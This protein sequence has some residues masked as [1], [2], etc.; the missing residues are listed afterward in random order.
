MD[1]ARVSVGKAFMAWLAV[2]V[3][4]CVMGMK[5]AAMA[6]MGTHTHRV[7]VPLTSHRFRR[8]ATRCLLSESLN[9]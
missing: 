8:P 4:G 1:E 3:D 7:R 6:I 9:V 5:T 2:V